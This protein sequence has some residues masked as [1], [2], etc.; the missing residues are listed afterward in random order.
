MSR[1]LSSLWRG[2]V[3][4][5]VLLALIS[6]SVEAQ[7]GTPPSGVWQYPVTISDR[8]YIPYTAS[9]YYGVYP[10]GVSAEKHHTGVDIG[11]TTS[12]EPIYAVDNGQVILVEYGWMTYWGYDVFINHGK[13]IDGNPINS[14]YAHMDSVLVEAGQFVTKGQQ[15]GIMGTPKGGTHLHWGRSNIAPEQF[16]K[17][18]LHASENGGYGWLDPLSQI[19]QASSQPTFLV[20]SDS[21]ATSADYLSDTVPTDQSFLNGQKLWNFRYPLMVFLGLFAVMALCLIFTSKEF[22]ALSVSMVAIIVLVIGV[23]Y[24]YTYTF[25]TSS[26]SPPRNFSYTVNT[27]D[28]GYQ[29]PIAEIGYTPPINGACS[30]PLSYPENIRRWC[31][32]IEFY[33]NQSGLDPRLIAAVML[34]ESGGNPLAYSSS[35]AV[36][37]LQVMPKDGIAATFVNAYGVPY[38]ANRP[39]ISQLQDPEYNIRYGVNMLAG[40]N[41]ANNPREA[42][43][44]YGPADV[45]YSY[46]DLVLS[47][48]SNYK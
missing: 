41:A 28:S 11:C 37:L 14:F 47:I 8:C 40:L 27:E 25:T 6:S 44:N 31:S 43:F 3:L 35:G 29:P 7:G 34:Q 45:G 12:N 48:Y 5:L 38:F 10:P 22:R 46:A 18:E 36:G 4:A 19:N 42:L 33:A 2:L 16:P 32:F 20:K 23:F 21:P 30:L 13:D 17:Y 9:V 15:I 39:S 1:H 24:F 26:N